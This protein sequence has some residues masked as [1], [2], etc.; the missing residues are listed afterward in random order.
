MKPRLARWLTRLYPREWRQRYGTEFEALLQTGRGDWRTFV[1]VFWSAF[2]ERLNPTPGV[3]KGQS[4][5][6]TFGIAPLVL[7]AG[8]YF[9]AC[10]ILWSGWHIFLPASDTPF[11]PIQGTAIVYFG[12]GRSLYHWAPVLVS[13]MA[14]FMAA[15][16]R[17]NAGWL[18]M[19]L[20][21]IAVMGSTARVQATGST[22][23]AGP[24]GV[25]MHFALGSLLRGDP[26]A[27]LHAGVI[28]CVGSLPY[29]TW[30]LRQAFT[31]P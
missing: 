13:W 7:L 4:P 12:M 23:S 22:V 11:V 3:G 21:I 8:A 16:E 29:V 14:A 2:S 28:L 25:S 19:A 9:I 15:R 10:F 24:G 18:V 17:S 5:W 26:G 1:N 6:V 31:R 30:R 27:L 20:L